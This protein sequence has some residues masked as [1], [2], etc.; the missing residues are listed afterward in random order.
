MSFNIRK[1]QRGDI[2]S[3]IIDNIMNSIT[4]FQFNGLLCRPVGAFN[5]LD[6][7]N[8]QG[9]ALRYR[10]SPLW[11]LLELLTENNCKCRFVQF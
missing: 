3:M 2:N 9:V 6:G 7:V 1:P 5:D 10:M 11:G 8:D 4:F